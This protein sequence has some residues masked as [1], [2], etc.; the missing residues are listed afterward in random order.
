MYNLAMS[1]AFVLCNKS[2]RKW[3]NFREYYDTIGKDVQKI[4]SSLSYRQQLQLE[5]TAA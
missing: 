1:E 4:L 3:V 2:H 5:I